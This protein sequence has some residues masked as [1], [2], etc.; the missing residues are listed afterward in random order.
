MD[1]S[2]VRTNLLGNKYS[3]LAE[4]IEDIRLIWHNAI[5]YNS[6]ASLAYKR[7][8]TM[9]T[10]FESLLSSSNVLPKDVNRPPT[11]D[12]LNALVARYSFLVTTSFLLFIIIITYSSILPLLV[13]IH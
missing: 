7:A 1:L 3:N 11:I 4:A 2:T 6:P 10:Y 5:V 9:S 8:K 12:E 13:F